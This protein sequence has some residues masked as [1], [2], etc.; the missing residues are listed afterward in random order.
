MMPYFTS[1]HSNTLAY[2]WQAYKAPQLLPKH[3]SN[4][5][6]HGSGVVRHTGQRYVNMWGYAYIATDVSETLLPGHRHI[7]SRSFRS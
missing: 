5:M 2:N 3:R 4:C 7:P 6:R 1:F